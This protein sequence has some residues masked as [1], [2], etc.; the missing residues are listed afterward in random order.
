MPGFSRL[1]LNLGVGTLHVF[2]LGISRMIKRGAL[3]HCPQCEHLRS[4]HQMRA[5]GSYID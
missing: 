2:T 4:R 5:D 1:G 3:R